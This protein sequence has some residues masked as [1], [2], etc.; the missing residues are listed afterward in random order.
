MSHGIVAGTTGSNSACSTRGLDL[1]GRWHPGFHFLQ[2]AIQ[3]LLIEIATLHENSTDPLDIPD[4]F[5]QIGV[6]HQQAEAF[7]TQG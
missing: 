7:P 1:F 5:K 6:E 4:V 2:E 3:R